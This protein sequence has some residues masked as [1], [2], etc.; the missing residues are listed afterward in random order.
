MAWW[1]IWSHLDQRWVAPWSK[2][3][4]KTSE[5]A[6]LRSA[7]LP[8]QHTIDCEC[9]R[10]P[11]KP[12]LNWWLTESWA[13]QMVVFLCWTTKF[14]GFM[15]ISNWYTTFH[16]ETSVISAFEQPSTNHVY[17]GTY[18][19]SHIW[20]LRESLACL[21]LLWIIPRTENRRQN[22]VSYISNYKG[23]LPLRWKGS[24]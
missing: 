22:Q 3:S 4:P 14:R 8:V 16:S 10:D 13:K 7:K 17:S 21:W 11:P 5:R 6:Q 2:Q 24:N 20:G 9:L 23:S 19:I 18:W 15:A 1:R 12:K